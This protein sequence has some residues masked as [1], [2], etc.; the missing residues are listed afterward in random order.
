[1]NA[2]H[3]SFSHMKCTLKSLSDQKRAKLPNCHKHYFP[4]N[5]TTTLQ[6]QYQRIH[7]WRE[8][9]GQRAAAHWEKN[10]DLFSLSVIESFIDFKVRPIS[11][12][13]KHKMQYSYQVDFL[14]G[15]LFPCVL[16]CGAGR[17]EDLSVFESA[18]KDRLLWKKKSWI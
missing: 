1:M 13:W 5:E 3:L 11:S 2:T 16:Y 15:N 8:I 9:E 7:Y 17:V 18:M 14:V 12:A 4:Q 6:M 10:K